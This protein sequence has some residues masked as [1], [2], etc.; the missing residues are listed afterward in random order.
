M[1]K[2]SKLASWLVFFLVFGIGTY[3]FYLYIFNVS[4]D[5]G[6]YLALSNRLRGEPLSSSFVRELKEPVYLILFW[7]LSN[8]FSATTSVFIAGFI[9][10]FLKSLII[11]KYAY[12]PFI[13]LFFYFL[14]FLP[15]HDTNQI[16]A[17]AAAAVFLYT[18]CGV[19]DLTKLKI[20]FLTFLAFLFHYSG[21][22]LLILLFEKRK[23]L[24]IIIALISSII[25]VPLFNYLSSISEAF[26]IF[27]RYSSETSPLGLTSP[28]FLLHFVI[29]IFS[30]LEW[31][32]FSDVEKRGALF[33]II[34][35]ACYVF[36]QDFNVIAVRFREIGFL[37]VMP[38]LFSQK[39]KLT[40][41]RLA[42]IL[43][44]IATAALTTIEV[45]SELIGKVL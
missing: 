45:W 14:V 4:N 19:K 28:Y 12:Y 1:D 41:S 31:K 44:S 7:F 32:N 17:A 36:F 25:F 23:Y 16:R 35:I 29:T 15:V 3:L 38:I 33:L 42:I 26:F 11:K 40:I 21:I 8:T 13:A 6:E 24:L 18:L 10:F 37:G 20:I 30:V 22:F 43:C 5:F 34:G 39:A 9:P 27:D 2:I